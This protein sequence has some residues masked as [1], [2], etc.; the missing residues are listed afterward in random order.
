[1]PEE[2][3]IVWRGDPNFSSLF[4]LPQSTRRSRAI[5]SPLRRVSILDS[6]CGETLWLA[7]AKA[8]S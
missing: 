7:Y 3:E 8:M 1:M 5:V 6:F 4:M 2:A